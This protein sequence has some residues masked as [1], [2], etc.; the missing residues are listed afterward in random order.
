VKLALQLTPEQAKLWPPV[1]EAVRARSMARFARWQRIAERF[2]S[3]GGDTSPVDRLRRRA[4]ALADRAA[5][6]RKLADAWQPLYESLDPAQKQR[7]GFLAVYVLREMRDLLQ[8]RRMQ[9][10]EDDTSYYYEDQ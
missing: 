1:E 10:D 2:N 3:Q 9:Y 6:L 5:G 8:S 7:L 4:D